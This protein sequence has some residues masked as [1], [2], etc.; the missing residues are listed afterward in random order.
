MSSLSVAFSVSF[1]VNSLSASV[2]MTSGSLALI[3]VS[4]AVGACSVVVVLVLT[5]S[6]RVL[7]G[8]GFLVA[9]NTGLGLTTVRGVVEDPL[10]SESLAVSVVL[11]RYPLEYLLTPGR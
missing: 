3:A 11:L 7:R 1:L 2:T 4:S 8:N 9:E 6:G 5:R 10:V